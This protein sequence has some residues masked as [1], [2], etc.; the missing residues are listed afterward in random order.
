MFLNSKRHD[1]LP[2]PSLIRLS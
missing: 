1:T 2:L